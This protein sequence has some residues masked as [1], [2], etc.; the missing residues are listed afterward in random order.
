M[1]DSQL[2]L[3]PRAADDPTR[4]TRPTSVLTPSADRKTIL[5]LPTID[6]SSQ[7]PPITDLERT[8]EYGEEGSLEQT[9]DRLETLDFD[10]PP[11]P[12]ATRDGES[13]P[14]ANSDNELTLDYDQA[15]LGRTADLDNTIDISKQSLSD[16]DLQATARYSPDESAAARG[17]THR[18]GSEGRLKR[19][20]RG[21]GGSASSP[22]HTL[23]GSGAL[24]SESIFE[25]V[26]QR[27]LFSDT[28]SEI[29]ALAQRRAKRDKERESELVR[30]CIEAACQS[31]RPALA[32]YV[33]NGYLGKG[34]MGIVLQAR[35]IAIGR[36]VALK[37]IQPSFDGSRSLSSTRDLHKKF[38]YEAQITGK[39]DHPNIVPIYELGTSNDVLFYTMKK[40]EGTEWKSKIGKLSRD[41]NLDILMKIADAMALSHRRHV[42]HRDL[43]PENIML[44]AFGE[45][46]V[47]D[48]GCAVD[49][50]LRESF[51]GAGSPPWMAPEM[52]LQ[53]HDKVGT[54]SD[55]YLLGAIL[56]QIITGKP[57][58]PGRTVMEVLLAASRNQ[59]IDVEH[60]DPLLDIAMKAMHSEPEGRYD[61]VEEM[62]EDIREYRRHSESIALVERSQATLEQAITSS[63]YEL[64]SRAMFGFQ[65]ALD[66]WPENSSARASLRKA[67]HAYGQ[68]ALG[69][70]DF[71]LCLATLD[72][73]EP[74][75]AA[76]HAQAEQAKQVALQ[77]E[78]RLKSLRKAF[79]AAILI[80]LATSSALATVA[81][82]QRNEAVSQKQIAEVAAESERKARE[83]EVAAK[84]KALQS[85]ESERLARENEEQAKNEAI[86][87]R[88]SAEQAA[89]SEKLAKE[90]A[91]VAKTAAEL[92]AENE[93]RAKV[94]TEQRTAQ[95]ELAGWR[96][97]LSLAMSQVEQLDIGRATELLQTLRDENS[98][99]TL[100]SM[101][102]VPKLDNWAWRRINLVSNRDLL[103]PPVDS[104]VTAL[105]YD[106]ATQWGVLASSHGQRNRLRLFR[107]ADDRLILDPRH[108]LDL[109]P[110]AVDG[111]MISPN[112]QQV[113]YAIQAGPAQPAVFRW[114]PGSNQSLPLS[115]LGARP[116]QGFAATAD[117]IV[118]GLNN[119]LWIW[120]AQAPADSAPERIAD[121]SGRMLSLQRIDDRHVL[122]LAQM[123]N[124]DRYPHIVPLDPNQRPHHLRV[125]F[126]PS[127]ERLSAVAYAR[128]QLILGTDSG[129]LFAT[130]YPMGSALAMA[131]DAGD[132]GVDIDPAGLVEIPQQHVSQIKSIKVHSD[133]TLLTVAE[134]P[135]ACLEARRYRLGWHHDLRLTGTTSNVSLV[136]FAGESDRCWPSLRREIDRL[137]CSVNSE[138]QQVRDWRPGWEEEAYDAR[139]LHPYL[140]LVNMRFNPRKRAD[141]PLEYSDRPERSRGRSA[142]VLHWS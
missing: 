136:E 58:H 85:A 119:G 79:A 142:A 14:P 53:Q 3:P 95:V 43:K 59:I 31:S 48:W 62:Q 77:R 87:A 49:L 70:K 129:R 15:R 114:L 120:K 135:L 50:S 67:R 2:D 30:Q 11:E 122:V 35:Q 74:A 71:D 13:A 110:T 56:F 38:F 140:R 89:E 66:L 12:L 109:G 26:S 107:V 52:A 81:W 92:A 20:W 113:I 1:T 91:I 47:T 65:D 116:L 100:A 32:D 117:V 46:L 112:G 76:L 105:A 42:I 84:I 7:P 96:S 64:Y 75:E 60:P 106:S 128:D 118:G 18:S 57:P 90:E 134:E 22:M 111:L 27:V 72:C 51:P 4:M 63:D 73:Q 28:T 141:R 133:G 132:S 121:I 99:Q 78:N 37:M 126:N 34:A 97:N 19:M 98:S 8:L 103:R 108:E 88:M 36:D 16:S 45:V 55:I 41:E 86:A 25:R 80:G 10:L 123:A 9:T 101:N 102:L 93:R 104:R 115:G 24:A 139:S 33:I 127:T 44:G 94:E 29:V 5:Q 124:G 40:I 23:K 137:G 131:A 68:C 125:R 83:D 54:R 138:R 39:L 130:A 61:T 69:R 21:S 82:L 17:E 6:L